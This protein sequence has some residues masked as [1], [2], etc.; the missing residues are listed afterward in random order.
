MN[1]VSIIFC[2]LTAFSFKAQTTLYFATSDGHMDKNSF[3]YVIQTS[4]LVITHDKTTSFKSDTT[5]NF[6]LLVDSN[7]VKCDWRKKPVKAVDV[8]GQLGYLT[9]DK[10]IIEL[11]E[12]E[13]NRHLKPSYIKGNKIYNFENQLVAFIEGDEM[14]G[15]ALYL[16]NN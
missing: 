12:K 8:Q 9:P 1:Y 3:R 6:I 11:S 2:L 4:G 10:K 16:L 5:H 7:M 13:N 15:V 14:F